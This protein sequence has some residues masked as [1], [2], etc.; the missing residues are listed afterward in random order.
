MKSYFKN[1]ISRKNIKKAFSQTA[2]SLKTSIPIMVSIFLILS[3]ISPLI[4]KYNT[5][6]FT[7]NFIFDPL[8]GSLMGSISFGIP[9]TS[10][11]TGG[12]LLA[13]G[14]NLV[15]VTAFMLAWTTV[16]IAML[17]LEISNL[18][19]KFAIVRNLVNFFFSIIIAILVVLTL[20]FI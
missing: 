15:A 9:I 8:I 13:G 12:E 17:P 18:G 4:K 2:K 5:E 10:Y 20:N 3:L 7:G 19:K 14:V 1:S 11:I 16:G 6:I